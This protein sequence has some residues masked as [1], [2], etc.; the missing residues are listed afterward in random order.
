MIITTEIIW[1]SLKVIFNMENEYVV[2]GWGW[3]ERFPYNVRGLADAAVCFLERPNAAAIVNPNRVDW[4]D[5][6]QGT[7]SGLYDVEKEYLEQVWGIVC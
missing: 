4:S 3:E 6:T 5:A 2:T 7:N 1:T